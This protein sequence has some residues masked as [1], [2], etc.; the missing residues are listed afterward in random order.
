MCHQPREAT[1]V[2]WF[3]NFVT[4]VFSPGIVSKT[5]VSESHFLVLDL[6]FSFYDVK[7]TLLSGSTFYF[8]CDLGF[9]PVF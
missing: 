3:A 5:G 7:D 4:A 2:T 9:L 1:T 6:E 8:T